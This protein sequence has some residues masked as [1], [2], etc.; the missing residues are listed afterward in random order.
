LGTTG[1][2][3]VEYYVGSSIG[4]LAGFE[5]WRARLPFRLGRLPV[6]SPLFLLAVRTFPGYGSKFV[7]LAAGMY[8]VPLFTY[9]WTAL[10]SS[11]FGALLVVLGAYG[12]LQL[13]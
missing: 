1:A 6:S 2:T 7:S 13:I 12:L 3:L 8:R 5:R 10:L 11:L 4:E 9:T